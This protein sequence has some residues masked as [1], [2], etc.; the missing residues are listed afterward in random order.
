MLRM[1]VAIQSIRDQGA[2]RESDYRKLPK[3][4]ARRVPTARRDFDRLRGPLRGHAARKP[5]L[6]DYFLGGRIRSIIK[7]A[8]YE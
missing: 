5:S 3:G 7:V 8:L 4:G 2:R 6:R 1:E